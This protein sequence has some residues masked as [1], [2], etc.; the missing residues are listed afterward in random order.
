[1]RQPKPVESSQHGARRSLNEIATTFDDEAPHSPLSSSELD[2]LWKEYAQNVTLANNAETQ[3]STVMS[4]L[5]T[6][7]A[8]V[9]YVLASLKFNPHYWPVAATVGLLGAFAALLTSIYHERW[10]SYMMLA[11][12]YR[13]RIGSAFPAVRLE[14]I[15]IAAMNAHQG[16]FARR[17][18]LYAAW[19]WLA[20]AVS[21]SGF[22][23]A[24]LMIAA[25]IAKS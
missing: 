2:I 7:I 25:V 15:R 1:M 11:R 16:E 8:A 22:A 5:F 12:G 23:C 17:V 21:I 9:V 6:A 20:I 4:F 24:A 14:E 10:M 19:Q 13:W 18:P 3:R